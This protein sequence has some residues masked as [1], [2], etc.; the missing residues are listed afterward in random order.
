MGE[1]LSISLR[2]K[3]LLVSFAVSVT[4]VGLLV[5]NAYL[6]YNIG[7]GFEPLAWVGF[8]VLIPP[9]L[10]YMLLS[11]IGIMPELRGRENFIESNPWLWIFCV[12]FYTIVI[13]VILGL[14]NSKKAQETQNS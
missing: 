12:I 6:T 5:G 11:G 2:P 13:Y 10:M 3:H 14:K 4:L 8:V 1:Y 7:G 9:G